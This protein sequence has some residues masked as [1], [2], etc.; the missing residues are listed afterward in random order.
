MENRFNRERVRFHTKKQN[1]LIVQGW[2][3][4][5]EKGQ[6]RFEA[7]LGN[8]KL[9]LE[10]VV[11]RGVEVTR[12]YLRYRTNVMAEYFL[13]AE[14]PGK[15]A[16]ALKGQTLRVFHCTAGTSDEEPRRDR[17]F[18]ISARNVER[19]GKRLES[20]ME[21]LREL[22]DGRYQLRGWYIGGEHVQLAILGGDGKEIPSEYVPG[23]RMDILSEFPEA[24]PEE[25]HGFEL[26]F[27]KPK[28]N[29]L[30][31]ALKGDGKKALYTINCEK[32][33]SGREGLV[34]LG[35][36]GWRY[37][38]RKGFKQFT[39]RVSDV[40]L[41]NESI[42]YE[43]WRRK[44]A[45]KPKELELQRSTHFPYEPKISIV[46]P[47]YR[48]PEKFLREMI[49]SVEKQT[50]ASWE[51]VLSDGSGD[52]GLTELLKEYAEK[53]PRIRILPDNGS[54]LRI[55]EN[56]NRALAAAAGDY[57]VFGD[58]DDLFS[59]DALWSCV[60][61]LNEK[62]KTELIYS[63][64][65]KTDTRGKRYFEPHFKPDYSPDLLCSMNYF[66]HLVLVKREL[67]E[68][69]GMLDP[70]FDGAQDY[71]YVLRCTEQT[72]PAQIV[73]I[74]K[75]LYH[76]RSHGD[77]TAENPESKQYAFEA[78]RRAVAAHY[79]RLGLDTVVKKGEYP[80]LYHTD[81]TIKSRADG[82]LPLISILIPNKDHTADLRKCILSIEEKSDYRNYEYIIIEN[83]ST[84]PETFEAYHELETAIPY[85]RVVNYQAEPGTGFNFSAL[86]NFGVQFARGEYY[87]LL[88][89]DTEII[90]PDC[91]RQML[92]YCQR[93]DVGAVGALLF[94]EDGIIQHAG[95]VLGFGGIAGHAFIGEKRGDNGY[96]SRIICAQNYSAV[97]AACMMVKASVYHE[98]G[99]MSEDLCVAFNDIDFCMKIRASGKL[100]VYTPQAQL[101]HYESKSRGLENTQ[102]KIER[103][104][105]ETAIFLSRWGDQVKAGDP[106]YNPNLTLD[107]ANFSLR[108]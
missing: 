106:Y 100:I 31:L 33:L 16:K 91:L 68:R 45:V 61:I 90:N 49:A 22:P 79:E 71:D 93:Q 103:F 13:M 25:T 59:P 27:E 4:G 85:L 81:F 70:A 57:L 48:T 54:S 99:G 76:W 44:Y 67:W 3:E 9:P 101:Y 58:H 28:E 23:K 20:W 40:L 52:N 38:Q 89:N 55:A 39:K 41:G 83:N 50:Y 7:W 53:D 97:T 75:I 87:L 72:D 42:G 56:T 69:T 96:F 108:T 29:Y 80:G 74:P 37:L 35:R 5:D 14:L 92:G 62:P 94:Y 77:S 30:R 43:Q 19:L 15:T 2:F 86:N 21:T 26:L 47:L 10:T 11:Q 73:H 66:C 64:E 46:V 51:L 63:D 18:Q 95:V 6:E 34:N 102:E 65:D 82:S 107:K 17:I 8:Q 1:T 105:Q 104:N 84:D 24:D 60:Q 36:K 88:N 12:K 32:M 78:G 98:V